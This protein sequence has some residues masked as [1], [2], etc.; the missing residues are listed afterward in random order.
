MSQVEAASDRGEHVQNHDLIHA[1]TKDTQVVT[2]RD[3]SDVQASASQAPSVTAS[4][5]ESRSSE[6]RKRERDAHP[7]YAKRDFYFIPIP[8]YLRYDP[9]G[10][11]HFDVFTN[12][13]FG[14]ASTFSELHF[15]RNVV[16]T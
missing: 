8:K 14:V 15:Y 16:G 12:I 7:D 3:S 10:P 6:S 11:T 5:V 9:H 2:P 1:N 4:A 13:L